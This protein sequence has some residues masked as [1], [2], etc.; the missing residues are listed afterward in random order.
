MRLYTDFLEE[1][2]NVKLASRYAKALYDFAVERKQLDE[3]YADVLVIT[4][5]LKIHKDLNRCIESPIIPHSKKV[6]IFVTIFEHNVSQVTLG[7]L[8]LL[9]EKKREPAL[10]LILEEF[11]K[12]YYHYHN[13]KI[14]NFV[15]SQPVGEELI[16]K[17]KSLL[18]DKTHSEVKMKTEINPQI[19]GGFILK[20]DD[21]VYD[22]SI[23][24]EIEK[25]KRDFSQNLY[26]PGF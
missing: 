11:V 19:L 25:L 24:R 6:G 26:Q 13:I 17:V 3:V 16:E 2:K 22:A 8:K 10:M 15:T 20:V 23:L 4:R 9:L 5:L 1:M 18:E 21:Y 7:F 14:A 12:C